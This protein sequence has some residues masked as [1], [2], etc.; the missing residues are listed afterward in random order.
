MK[1]IITIIIA[2]LLAIVTAAIL[3]AQ[4][5][6]EGTE[7]KYISEIKIG[8][9]KKADKA[10]AALKGYEV[11][12]G[13]DGKPVDLNKDAGGGT[14]SK[15]QKVVYLG[16]KKTSN[17]SEAITDLALMNMKGG[18]STD[19]Y[20]ALMGTYMKS[21][22]TPFVD[23]FLAAIREYRE[24]YKSSNEKNRARAKYIHDMLNM[25]FD[26]DCGGALIGDLLLNETKYE[27]GD[28]AYNKLSAAEKKKHADILTIVAQSNGKAMLMMENLLT[29]AADTSESSWLDR[30]AEMTYDDIV[31]ETGL[32]PSKAAKELNKLY[33]DDA[34]GMAEMWDTFRTALEGYDEDVSLV[35]SFD[36]KKANAALDAMENLTENSSK[37]EVE[38][39]VE[40]FSDSQVD[41]VKV[42]QAAERIAVHDYLA[43]VE[44]EGGTLLD[45]FLQPIDEDEADYSMLF[46]LIASFSEGQRAGLEFVS[47]QE[48]CVMAM[49][50]SDGYKEAAVDITEK[51]SI[52]DGIDR[53]I[54]EPG[55]VGLTSDAQR[56][57]AL[58]NA[59][60][61]ESGVF[62]NTTRAMMIATA[63]CFGAFAA[64]A[65]VLS[66]FGVARLMYNQYIKNE[67]IYYNEA[68]G[69]VRE[70]S[71]WDVI[72][73]NERNEYPYRVITKGTTVSGWMTVGLS[74]VMIIMT[75]ISLWLTFRELKEHYKVDFTPI[76]RYMVDEKDIVAYNNKGEKIML[77]NQAAY[78]KAVECNR[79]EDAEFYKVLSVYADLNGDVGKQWLALYAERNEMNDPILAGSFKA[80]SD[81]KIPA[82][83][84]TGIH[85][86]GSS[87]VENLNNPLYDWNES[88]PKVFVY[89]KVDVGAAAA[90][91]SVAASTFSIGT[92]AL[93]AG[94]GLFIGIIATTFIMLNARKKKEK[95]AA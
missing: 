50:D 10:L 39:A 33:Y 49:T 63:V 91:T 13:S 66:G 6:A 74:V 65:L 83:Y 28:A 94:A 56:T 43:G 81:E 15:G 53:G 62:S 22:V 30:L 60:E 87:A 21:E 41:T 86:F 71:T 26:D 45:Y 31:D 2:L 70:W 47:L 68:F 51:V 85:M 25:Y 48:L 4:V 44:Y 82:G 1:K 34:E 32:S 79:T 72:T 24:N 59:V 64:S 14:G 17:K 88:A 11:L 27:M 54:F 7:E 9:D 46:P 75:S 57:R 42:Y 90:N 16:Y 95:S 92:I 69:E 61:E 58:E 77:K 40:E 23:S 35:E 20:D 19:D 80:V 73:V 93:S 36:E 3:P 52:Y 78:Y 76:P 89:Y 18:Y 29:R 8:M 12:K 67:V 84:E 5:F 38:K 55:G 37:N